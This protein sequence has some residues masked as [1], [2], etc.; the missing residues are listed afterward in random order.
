MNGEPYPACYCT[1][2]GLPCDTIEQ[3]E[4]EVKEHFNMAC[5]LTD[6]EKGKT[7]TPNDWIEE[8]KRMCVGSNGEMVTDPN[9]SLVFIHKILTQ[10]K[11]AI[12]KEQEDLS[13]ADQ[14]PNDNGKSTITN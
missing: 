7:P 11:E 14:T 4:G 10:Q 3:N 12:E 13:R 6:L 2:C 9:V 8:F 5:G 1:K